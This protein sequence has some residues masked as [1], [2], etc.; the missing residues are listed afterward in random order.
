M[1]KSVFGFLKRNWATI[2][3]GIL[4]VVMCYWVY[5]GSFTATA[6]CLFA[7]FAGMEI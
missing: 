5:L 3:R 2:V 1:F 7:I 4:A 6:L